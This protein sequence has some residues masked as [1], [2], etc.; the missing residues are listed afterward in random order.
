MQTAD[1][2]A[3]V[4]AVT[5]AVLVGVLAAA[6]V[7]VMRT[8]RD[9]R[10]AAD[11]LRTEA[12]PLVDELRGAVRDASHEVERV[13]R[14]VTSAEQLGDAVDHASRLAYRT[15]A[16]PVV[17]VMA[18][19]TGVARA[20]DRLRGDAPTPDAVPVNAAPEHAHGRRR[21]RRRRSGARLG[22]RDS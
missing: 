8:L 21:R 5:V 19:G 15:L 6:L 4:V 18:L 13:D 1:V 10:D 20:R 12:L 16:S 2:L 3:I 14:L 17:K 9:L 11:A 7:V 22:R